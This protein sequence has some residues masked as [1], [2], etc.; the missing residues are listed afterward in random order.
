MKYRLEIY[1]SKLINVMLIMS[2]NK[3][4]Q[5]N[6]MNHSFKFIVHPN[7]T[8]N[9]EITT[10]LQYCALKNIL[11]NFDSN[12]IK[13][14]EYNNQ[15]V[16]FSDEITDVEPDASFTE[17][18]QKK[19]DKRN[20]FISMCL[21]NSNDLSLFFDAISEIEYP[22]SFKDLR[23]WEYNDI[24]PDDYSVN[25]LYTIFMRYEYAKR[26]LSKYIPKNSEEICYAQITRNTANDIKIYYD[27]CYT[28]FT[29]ISSNCEDEKSKEEYIKLVNCINENID[30]QILKNNGHIE[31]TYDEL[32]VYTEDPTIIHNVLKNNQVIID[33][34]ASNIHYINYV[35]HK[36]YSR[37][38]VVFNELQTSITN[39]VNTYE[40]TLKEIGDNLAVLND[41][42][43]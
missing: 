22:G 19:Q 2:V 3:S 40:S 15:P 37:R 14:F 38:S 5:N 13:S 41:L 39:I 33:K 30:F 36:K 7:R 11:S 32:C 25:D 16:L 17:Y 31:N 42:F 43:K 28:K 35:L 1:L 10:L 20:D 8:E 4:F 9:V 18:I 12:Y 6:K 23:P 26:Y 24:V 29:I 27:D 21:D 34:M